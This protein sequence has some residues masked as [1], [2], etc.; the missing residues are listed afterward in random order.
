[1]IFSTVIPVH[2]AE[3]ALNGWSN[4]YNS[5][6]VVCGIPV[7]TDSETDVLNKSGIFDIS[8]N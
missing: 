5:I 7:M 6:T 3:Y 8:S 4:Y 1:M 2:N